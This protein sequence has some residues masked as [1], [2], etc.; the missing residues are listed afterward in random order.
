MGR[1]M[2]RVKSGA[3]SLAVKPETAALAMLLIEA[4]QFRHRE[5]RVEQVE[6]DRLEMDVLAELLL[7]FSEDI[8]VVESERR[9]IL[10][11]EPAR[12]ARVVAVAHLRRPHQRVEGDGDHALT[13]TGTEFPLPQKKRPV[14]AIS[15][16]FVFL[17]S[18]F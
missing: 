18:K 1:L 7:R 17:R 2:A 9:G 10:Y 3:I 8:V 16:I 12:V 15:V 4:L 11:G 5:G 6:P 13:R 14:S